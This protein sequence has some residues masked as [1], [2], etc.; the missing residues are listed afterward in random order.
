MIEQKIIDAITRQDW[1]EPPGQALQQAVSKTFESGGS[2]GQKIM[3]LLHGVG[4]GFPLH[5][6]LTDIPTGSWTA[7]L[8]L[9]ALD[10]WNGDENY[11][12]A[13]DV[14]IAVGLVGAMG[15]VPTGLT[16][17][18]HLSSKPLRI[19]F[20]HGMMNISAT[21]LYSASLMLRRRNAR[22]A[23]KGIALGAYV[24]A[25][26]SAHLGGALVY[27]QKIGVNHS[28]PVWTPME[29]VPVLAEEELFEG[30][31][32]RVEVGDRRVLLVRQNGEVYA[33]SEVCSHLGG[34]L[35][36]GELRDN[37]VVCPWHGSRFALSDGRPL[38]GPATVPQPWFEVRVR[39][40]QIEVR[41]AET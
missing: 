4:L 40:G 35:A 24:V 7:A 5:P 9:D 33:L 10:T 15:A 21:I 12:R 2:A 38:D 29:F 20:I 32:R 18:H 39:N 23:G 25:V 27:K 11:G 41:A 13:A 19:G 16:D 14:T 34:P 6:I 37:S 28:E 30:E 22:S 31:K 36:D 3:N 26:L 17:W 1:L 8:V